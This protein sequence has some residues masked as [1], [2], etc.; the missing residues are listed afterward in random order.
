MWKNEQP[1][2]AVKQL[3]CRTARRYFNVLLI[4]T[5]MPKR[6][7]V[8]KK[9]LMLCASADDPKIELSHDN[10][11][12]DDWLIAKLHL[13]IATM[14]LGTNVNVATLTRDNTLLRHTTNHTVPDLKVPFQAMTSSDRG[15][16]LIR[17]QFMF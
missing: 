17:T 9:D 3:I 12:A 13:D 10:C 1:P 6:R 5:W 8:F 16:H 2:D 11:G 4:F 14:L 15:A 7:Q